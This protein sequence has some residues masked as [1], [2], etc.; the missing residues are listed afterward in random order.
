MIILYFYAKLHDNVTED[1]RHGSIREWECS[2]LI[3][4]YFVSHSHLFSL[5]PFGFLIITRIIS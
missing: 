5:I 2:G 1:L 4:S 3:I